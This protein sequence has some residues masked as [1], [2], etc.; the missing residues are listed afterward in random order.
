[1][2]LIRLTQTFARQ[3]KLLTNPPLAATIVLFLFCGLTTAQA[4]V[5]I[6]ANMSK[7]DRLEALRIM[8]FGTSSKILTDPYPLGGYSGLEIGIAVENLP[9]DDLARLGSRVSSPQQEVSYP[10]FTIG[11][12][13][14]ND[15]DLFFNFTPYN[16]QDQVSQ[17]GAMV[18][19]GFYQATLLPFSASIIGH[20]NSANINNQLTARTYGI[21]V[22]GG[23][24]VNNVSLF[25]GAG[26]LQSTGRFI[27]GP[28]GITD[29]Q[30]LETESVSGLHTV[31]GATVHISKFFLA[32]QIDRY[33]TP[34][35][36]AKLGFR[37]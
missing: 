29:T 14:Y 28:R 20:F 10:K 31:I 3:L 4:A 19:W 30:E 15:V 37:F 32:A 5:Q 21:D 17:W 11:K 6:P 22:I 16:R 25:A 35:F 7:N 13:L 12:G 27:G 36:S 18:R 9:T 33:T 1:M 8:G 34:V 23:I 24:N 2:T 26:S